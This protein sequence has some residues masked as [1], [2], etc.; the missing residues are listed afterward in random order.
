MWCSSG[1]ARAGPEW[2]GTGGA[3]RRRT[4]RGFRRRMGRDRS[5]HSSVNCF[6]FFL[7][8]APLLA[9]AREPP[10]RETLRLSPDTDEPAIHYPVA[11]SWRSESARF[12]GV[13]RDSDGSCPAGLR[14]SP[15]GLHRSPSLAGL[16][17]S[18][19]P[20]R[21]CL[22]DS[23]TRFRLAVKK[24]CGASVRTSNQTIRGTRSNSNG[25]DKTIKKGF[26]IQFSHL[27]P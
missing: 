21:R 9:A 26:S 19:S 12:G 18:G 22:G 20:S 16:G 24:G 27:P 15:G 3:L 1:P 23:D 13:R 4:S 25:T 11:L 10:H 6:F 8:A 2:S 5:P 17:S 7:G 14:L